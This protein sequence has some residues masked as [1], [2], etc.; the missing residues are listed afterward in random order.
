M[1]HARNSLFSRIFR[2]RQRV[3]AHQAQLSAIAIEIETRIVRTLL[4]VRVAPNADCNGRRVAETT[5]DAAENKNQFRHHFMAALATFHPT[6]IALAT[7]SSSSICAR[8]LSRMGLRP[9][10]CVHSGVDVDAALLHIFVLTHAE[11][12]KQ[13]TRGIRAG[14]C[15][16]ASANTECDTLGSSSILH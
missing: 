16:A 10:E 7:H 5:E 11:V 12:G 2:N 4:F 14:H 3:S 1:A 15:T 13:A 8:I 6:R 9:P